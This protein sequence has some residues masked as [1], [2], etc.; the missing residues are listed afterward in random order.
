[1]GLSSSRNIGFQKATGKYLYN[2]DG[3]DFLIAGALKRLYTCA[4][5]IIWIYLD[6]LRL[7]FRE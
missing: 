4:E 5:K 3:D 6:F 2:I 7:L 1:M